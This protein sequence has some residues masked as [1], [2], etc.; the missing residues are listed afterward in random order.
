L[1]D[2]LS[3]HEQE[4]ALDVDPV[5]WTGPAVFLRDGDRLLHVPGRITARITDDPELGFDV[6]LEVTVDGDGTPRCSG[7][8]LKQRADGAYI[9]PSSLR[10]LGLH[11]WMRDA[12]RMAAT[13]VDVT[14]QDGATV[15]TIERTGLF[16][17][18]AATEPRTR[19][20]RND[21]P[22]DD[23]RRAAELY[24]QAKAEGR[25]KALEWVADQLGL[26]RSTAYNWVRRGRELT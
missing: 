1:D 21:P 25:P 15:I 14:E 2:V 24:E 26:T 4:P 11:G 22:E 18:P 19:P 10:A 5:D 17:E 16:A 7:L 23:V 12:V 6:E 3:N 9:A 8:S 13:E 20:R